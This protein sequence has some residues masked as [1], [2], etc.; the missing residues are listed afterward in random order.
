VTSAHGRPAARRRRVR[1]DEVP[2]IG[3]GRRQASPTLVEAPHT[4]P[5]SPHPLHGPSK[6]DRRVR[7][8][9]CGIV[10]AGD[11]RLLA[12][13]PR[14]SGSNPDQPK[15]GS[16]VRQSSAAGRLLPLVTPRP[17]DPGS[18]RP[19]AGGWR[20]AAGGW[21]QAAGSRRAGAHRFSLSLKRRH[22]TAHTSACTTRPSP[23]LPAC[24]TVRPPCTNDPKGPKHPDHPGVTTLSGRYTP[25][26]QA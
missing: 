2:I 25:T 17:H 15:A 5:H 14:V 24:R 18:H 26:I 23:C 16:S 1:A 12:C 8:V 10:R 3:G 21:Q 4:T 22:V 7:T 19:A 9:G 6:S 13:S 20:L 11:E